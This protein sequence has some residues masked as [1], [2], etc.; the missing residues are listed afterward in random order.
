MQITL[1][2]NGMMCPM[3]KARVEKALAAVEGVQN[4]EVSLEEKTAAV[5][6]EAL[7]AAVLKNAVINA[8]YEI[9]E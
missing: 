9:A 6:G 7:D 8:G 2:V 5:C 4:V 3:C 1:H